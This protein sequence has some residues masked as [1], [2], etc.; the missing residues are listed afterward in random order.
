MNRIGG[1]QMNLRRMAALAVPAFVAL[2]AMITPAE[3]G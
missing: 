1:N 3:A 2:A